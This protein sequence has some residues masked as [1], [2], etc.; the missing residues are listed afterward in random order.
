MPS[1]LISHYRILDHLGSGGMGAVYRAE[2]NTLHRTVALKFITEAV[3]H[4]PKVYERLRREACTASALNHPNICTIYEVGEDAGEM[5][6]AMEYIEGRTLA[7]LIRQGPLPAETVL[8]YGCQIISALAHA[9]EKGVVHGDLKPPN[10]I[11]TPF[12]EAKILDFGLARR[13]NPAEFDRKTF[14]TASAESSPGLGG[15]FPYMAPEQIE[16]SD[17]SART[18]IWSFGIVLYEMLTGTRPFQGENLFLLCNSILRDTPRPFPSEVLPGFST[19]I[20]RCLEKEPERRYRRAGEARAA[21]ETLT[22]SMQK[23][24]LLPRRTE[25][26]RPRSTL[27]VL[28]LLVLLA[29]VVLAIRGNLR[30]G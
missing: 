2:D 4:S 21:L 14:E 13:S 3:A 17:A 18:D 27:I 10:I 25:W 9:H 23:E 29:A 11:V 30:W 26:F 1:Q 20:S 15:T 22:P 8:R 16:G 28:A 24:A 19:I 6:I 12:G 7:E 5:F